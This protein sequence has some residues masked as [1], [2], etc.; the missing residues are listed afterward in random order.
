M[1]SIGEAMAVIQEGG[2]M[3]TAAQEVLAVYPHVARAKA[4]MTVECNQ[5]L[6]RAILVQM[7]G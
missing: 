5:M 1:I 2:A 6:G 7:I 3:Q 4:V